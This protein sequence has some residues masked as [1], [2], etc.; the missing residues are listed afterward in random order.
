MPKQK[1]IIYQIIIIGI[2]HIPPEAKPHDDIL[3]QNTIIKKNGI[4]FSKIT[5]NNYF[6]INIILF[7]KPFDGQT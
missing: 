4:I 3:K 1:T 2:G 6:Y 7:R 5:D